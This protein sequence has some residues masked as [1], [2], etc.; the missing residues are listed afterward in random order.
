M[1]ESH[2]IIGYCLDTLNCTSS[3]GCDISNIGG[4]IK[5]DNKLLTLSRE[6]IKYGMEELIDHFKLYSESFSIIYNEANSFTETPKGELGV[7]IISDDTNKPFRAHVRS[8]G[9]AHLQSL[10]MMAKG[11][12]IADLVA[13]IGTQDVVFGEIDR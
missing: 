13:I 1:H 4:S 5:S 7:F 2:K 9:F 12:M 6:S 8:T 10:N 3:L 11:Y